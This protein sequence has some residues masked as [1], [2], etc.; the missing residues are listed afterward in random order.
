LAPTQ[1]TIVPVADRHVDHA[2]GVAADLRDRGLRVAVDAADDTVGE[3][4]RRAITA[5]HPAVLVVGD[6]DLAGGTVGLRVRGSDEERRGVPL[7]DAAA[8]LVAL[9]APPR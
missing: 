1:A 3:K 2:L 9:C 5:K 6:D 7:V 4:I 8:E